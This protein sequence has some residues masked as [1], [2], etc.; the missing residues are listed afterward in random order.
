VRSIYDID[1]PDLANEFVERLGH[2][3]Q[4]ESCPPEVRQLGRT[5]VRWRH[6]V[7][8]WHHVRVSSGPTEAINNLIKSVTRS[9]SV[10]PLRPLPDPSNALRRQAQLGTTRHQ[11]APLKREAP[12]MSPAPTS[13][14]AD[15]P[16]AICGLQ[17][18]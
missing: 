16:R 6:Q 3:L 9:R 18:R 8:A 17:G 14:A 13:I 7:D 15:D 5:I 12:A 11:Q 10:P 1:D 2:D 4:D